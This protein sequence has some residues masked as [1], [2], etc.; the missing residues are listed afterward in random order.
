MPTPA[1]PPGEPAAVAPAARPP[2]R[3]RRS[4]RTRIDRELTRPMVW[5]ALVFLVVMAPALPHA[6]VSIDDGASTGGTPAQR[7]TLLNNLAVAALLVLAAPFWIEAILRLAYV[8]RPTGR[9]S[10]APG[11]SRG[12]IAWILC[13]A[14]VPPLRTGLHPATMRGHMWLPLIGWRRTSARLARQVQRAFGMPMLLIGLLILPVLV[15]ELLLSQQVQ[16]SPGLALGL[17]VATRLI[18]LAFALEFIIMMAVTPRRT[19]YAFR[20][21]VDLVII[22]LPFVAFLR[23]LRV[24]RAGQLLKAQQMSQLA[25]TYRL[26]AVAVKL[27]QAL[28]LLRVL[29]GIS[30]RAAKGRISRLR[31]QITRRHAEIEELQA[32]LRELRLELARRKRSKRSR[33]QGRKTSKPAAASGG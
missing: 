22:L 14:L 18:W 3:R 26:R 28:L 33:R 13:C 24:L 31:D 10:G 4:L 21:W 12:R 9:R 25:R 32:E 27:L 29:E 20:H 6:F 1:N 19:E 2:L 30:E 23:S 7:L 8:E 17:D 11:P 5:L 15:G 16:A